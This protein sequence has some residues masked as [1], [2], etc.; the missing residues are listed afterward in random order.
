[1][2]R[3]IRILGIDPGLRRTGWGMVA[4]DG[5]RLT[6]LA[7]GSVATEDKAALSPGQQQWVSDIQESGRHLLVL[8]NRVLDLAK[9]EAGRASFELEAVD[10]AEAVASA[11]TLV[12]V[13]YG[14]DGAPPFMNCRSKNSP[15]AVVTVFQVRHSRKSWMSSGMTSS[16]TA[17][18]FSSRRCFRS[19]V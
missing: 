10:P 4:I 14:C 13:R 1:M 8:I 2:A 12:R 17:T 18:P 11:Q 6:F 5:N 9:I 19:T 15:V 3:P 16:S 7:C